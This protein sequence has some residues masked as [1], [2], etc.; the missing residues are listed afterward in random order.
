MKS[1]TVRSVLLILVVFFL[2]KE[3]IEEEAYVMFNIPNKVRS[4]VSNPKEKM[5]FRRWNCDFNLLKTKRNLLY[6][7]TQSVPHSKIFPPRL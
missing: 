7:N 4:S 1:I 6:L 2:K 3:K 5:P